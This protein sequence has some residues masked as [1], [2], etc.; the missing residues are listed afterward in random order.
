MTKFNP[1][2]RIFGLAFAICLLASASPGQVVINEVLYRT[3]PANADPLRSQQWVELYNKGGAP[4]DL[5]GWKLTGRAGVNGPSARALP[6]VTISAAGYVVIHFAV[7]I[8]TPTDYYTQDQNAI[9][10]Q[11]MDE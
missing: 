3:D 6:S 10:D 11:N 5:T 1:G 8:S 4:V 9:F 2:K 7:G